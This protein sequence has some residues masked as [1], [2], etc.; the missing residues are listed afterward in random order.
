MKSVAGP[1]MTLGNAAAAP[2]PVDRLVQ[3]L[4]A[5]G[6]TR[7]AVWLAIRACMRLSCGGLSRFKEKRF[8][9]C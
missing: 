4:P 9:N 6:R 2:R 7:L 5:S 3:G 8:I 1:P